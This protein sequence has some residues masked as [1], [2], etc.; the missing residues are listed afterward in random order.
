MPTVLTK[1]LWFP[2]P[3]SAQ[4]GGEFDGLVAIGGDFSSPRLLLAYRSGI[5]PWT[6][7]PITWW[8]PDPRAILELDRFHVS[9][10]LARVIR[11]GVF[12]ITIDRAPQRKCSRIASGSEQ[13]LILRSSTSSS[14]TLPREIALPTTTRSSSLVMCSAR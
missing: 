8:S 4:S 11:K 12:A 2:D 10:S 7:D 14:S 1:R 9:E 6:D 5:F 3:R 13:Y